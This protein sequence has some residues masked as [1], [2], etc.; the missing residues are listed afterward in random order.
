MTTAPDTVGPQ[1]LVK[2]A[3]SVYDNAYAPYSHYRVSA[4]VLADDGTIYT[5]CNVENAVYP[6][7]ICAERVAIFKAVSEGAPKIVAVAVVT[8]K[9]VPCP[10]DSLTVARMVTGSPGL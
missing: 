2:A 8:A 10:S 7:T 5:G 6:L 1:D 3:Q 4:A 9:F